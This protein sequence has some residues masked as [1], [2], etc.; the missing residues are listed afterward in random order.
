MAGL[1]LD[2]LR[3]TYGE[4]RIQEQNKR[5]ETQV[6]SG[7]RRSPWERDHI[8]CHLIYRIE[9]KERAALVEVLAIRNRS[10]GRRRELSG[11]S[12]DLGFEHQTEYFASVC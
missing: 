6:C 8:G 4:N 1:L 7:N 5:F 10:T 9:V 2:A 12:L 3:Q 11:Q